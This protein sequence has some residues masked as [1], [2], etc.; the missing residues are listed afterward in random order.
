MTQLDRK[1]LTFAMFLSVLAGYVDALGFLDLNGY[2]V[3]FMSGNSTRL[4]VGIGRANFA[5]AE[6]AA[7]IIGL[8]VIGVV[9]GSVVARRAGDNR[10]KRIFL[11]V[12]MLLVL[13]AVSEN[14]HLKVFSLM[15]MVLAMGAEN[16]ILRRDGIS[17]GLTYMTGNLV[18]MGQSLADHLY[19]ETKFEWLRYLSLWIALVLGATAGTFAYQHFGMN[20]LWFAAI[21]CF[22][23]VGGSRFSTP[24]PD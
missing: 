5:Q 8:F 6:K 12:G 4:G 19:G 14:C 20:G 3:S 11:M 15:T 18:K 7:F 23:F 24:V 2:F 9:A 13:S 17:I 22:V 1:S 10:R 21:T 16:T